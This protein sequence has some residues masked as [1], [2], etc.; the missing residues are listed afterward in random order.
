VDDAE[1]V[2][3]LWAQ[4]LD[5]AYRIED[6]EVQILKFFDHCCLLLAQEG[7]F[8]QVW[9]HICVAVATKVLDGMRQGRSGKA[10]AH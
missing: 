4:C 3:A 9:E 6:V 5:R 8:R 7:E 10:V 2:A 1:A